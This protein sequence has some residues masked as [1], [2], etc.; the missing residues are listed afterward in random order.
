MKCARCQNTIISLIKFRE[1]EF[2]SWYCADYPYGGY[3][4]LKKP[5]PKA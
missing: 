5:K 3:D 2:C 4:G 1:K